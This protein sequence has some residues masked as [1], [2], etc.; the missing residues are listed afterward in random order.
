MTPTRCASGPAAA[1]GSSS[2]AKIRQR[3][4]ETAHRGEVDPGGHVSYTKAF[5]ELP[6]IEIGSATHACL[7]CR[8]QSAAGKSPPT[9]P[10][11]SP[12]RH[13]SSRCARAELRCTGSLAMCFLDV[14]CPIS[15]RD[16]SSARAARSACFA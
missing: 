12:L 4:L 5:D 14:G 15:V 13:E 6:R 11:V 9:S 1:R 16:R 3:A 10:T 7:L 8:R 2:R